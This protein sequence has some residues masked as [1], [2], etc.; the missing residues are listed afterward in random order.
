MIALDTN[1]LLRYFVQDDPAQAKTATRIIERLTPANPAFLS[2]I[3]ICELI[4]ALRTVYKI[5]RETRATIL[6]NLFAT[7][8][9][10]IENFNAAYKAPQHYTEGKA[11]FSDYLIREIA[12]Q[13]GCDRVVTFD[14]IA[15]KED[16]FAAA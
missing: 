13:A 7:E 6:G 15:L 11:D 16:G 14:K 12:R 1:I 4:W 9:F 5:P 2:L 8:D 10:E 3:V